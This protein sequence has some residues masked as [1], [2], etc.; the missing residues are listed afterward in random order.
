MI[1]LSLTSSVKVL[2]FS[3]FLP[4]GFSRR[5]IAE[6]EAPYL[7]FNPQSSALINLKIK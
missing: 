3:I 7:A 5:I 4:T 2:T 1:L 6:F